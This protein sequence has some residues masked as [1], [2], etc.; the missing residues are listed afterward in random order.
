MHKS[1]SDGL[2]MHLRAPKISKFSWGAMPPDPPTAHSYW[3]KG[4]QLYNLPRASWTLVAALMSWYIKSIRSFLTC[5]VCLLMVGSE[6]VW[7]LGEGSNFQLVRGPQ[8]WVLGHFQAEGVVWPKFLLKV[9]YTLKLPI[10]PY[11]WFGDCHTRRF[12]P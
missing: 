8:N 4:P 3:P 5:S 9:V 7:G 12:L 11:S 2:R 10:Y 1:A 6:C